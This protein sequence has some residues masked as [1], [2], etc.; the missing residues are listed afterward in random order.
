MTITDEQYIEAARKTDCL[1]ELC[2]FSEYD[3]DVGRVPEHWLPKYMP[4]VD[5][6]QAAAPSPAIT[7]VLEERQQ[8]DAQSGG[9][10]HDDKHDEGDFL[11]YIGNQVGKAIADYDKA[12]TPADEAAAFRA[13]F[14]K[15]AA[16]A[17]AAIESIDRKAQA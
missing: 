3:P 7:A 16:L 15:I 10:A 9:P 2:R 14:V 12:A 8:Q 5:A 17:V 1:A 6:L 13:R 4:F 11:E